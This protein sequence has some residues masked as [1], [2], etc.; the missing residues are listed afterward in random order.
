MKNGFEPVTDRASL[1]FSLQS[2]DTDVIPGTLTAS[3]MY[4][5]SGFSM[6]T[7]GN[8]SFFFGEF[9]GCTGEPSN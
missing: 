7:V 9:E 2:D 5:Q 3:G 4:M 6:K 1:L 8:V